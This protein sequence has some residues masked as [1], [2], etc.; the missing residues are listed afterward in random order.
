VGKISLEDVKKVLINSDVVSDIY[1]AAIDDNR[2][3]DFLLAAGNVVSAYDAN[4]SLLF[5]KITP[6][7]VDAVSWYSDDSRKYMFALN[8]AEK[9][10][11]ISDMLTGKTVTGNSGSLPLVSDLFRNNKLYVVTTTGNIVECS[12]LLR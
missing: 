12:T 6:S 11:H 3:T 5:N 9:K 2:T 8:R 1:F 7:D 4:G 10:L